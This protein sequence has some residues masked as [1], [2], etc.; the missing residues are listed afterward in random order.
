[1]AETFSGRQTPE[2]A[3]WEVPMRELPRGL[4][5]IGFVIGV[6]G[7]SLLPAQAAAPDMSCKGLRFVFFPGGSEGDSFAA[8]VYNGA[9]LAAQQTGCQVDYVWSD[10]NPEKMIEQ[11]K[12]AVARR[13][14]GISIMGH[15][16]DPA[17]DSLIDEARSRGIIVTTANVDLPQAEAKYKIDGMGY[18]GQKLYDSGMSLGKATVKACALKAGDTALVWGLLGQEA[19]GQRSKGVIDALK[20][21]G[22]K[23]EYLEISDA[24]NKEAAQGTPVFTSFAAAHPDLKAVV[25]DHGLLTATL[26][27]FLRTAG[28]QPKQVCGAGFDLSAATAA[29][30]KEGWVSV[31]L[32]QQPFLEGYFPILQLYLSKR[33]GFA[34]LDIDTGAALITAQN[35]DQVAPLAEAAIR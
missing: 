4:L 16:G 19:R 30:I 10:W 7:L 21:A 31:V 2:D 3:G 24:V 34:G 35:I 12:E 22:V 1:V 27:T 15:P 26:S 14:D 18:V 8:I 32:D 6:L 9:K 25:T 20:G 28:K 5:C 33:F 11:F 29:A 17:F 23:V 13:P